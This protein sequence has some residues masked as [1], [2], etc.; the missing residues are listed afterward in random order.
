VSVLL[1][2]GDGSFGSAAGYAVGKNPSSIAVGDFN[3]DRKADLV[4][5]SYMG[6]EVRVLLAN[7]NGSFAPAVPYPVGGSGPGAVVVGDFNGDG[8]LDFAT[9]VWNVFLGKG[10]GSFSLPVGVPAYAGP[11]LLATGDLNGDGKLDLVVASENFA[12]PELGNG[13]GTFKNSMINHIVGNPDVWSEA[14][15]LGDFNGDG[16][17][18]IA[19]ANTGEDR[20]GILLGNGD[21]T[22]PPGGYLNDFVAGWSPSDVATGDFNGDG[23]PDIACADG[24]GLSI[25]LNSSCAR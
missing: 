17:L 24:N 13:D 6:Q 2:N 16:K 10:D 11:V 22:F 25:L 21:G 4:V 8:K 5:A 9:D 1:G 20:V 15:S 23:R 19:S 3:G 14:I 12:L 18:D 7:G